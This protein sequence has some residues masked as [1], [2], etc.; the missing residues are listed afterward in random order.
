MRRRFELTVTQR[1]VTGRSVTWAEVIRRLR[2]AGFEPER[3]GKGS[4]SLGPHQEGR[5]NLGNRILR[6]AG[7][8]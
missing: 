4:H 2:K 1:L 6:E 5:Q 8:K 3:H 7:I